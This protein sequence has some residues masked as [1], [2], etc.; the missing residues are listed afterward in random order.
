MEISFG[1]KINIMEVYEIDLKIQQQIKKEN[2]FFFMNK[3]N[4]LDNFF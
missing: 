2:S 1:L 3:K 4:S